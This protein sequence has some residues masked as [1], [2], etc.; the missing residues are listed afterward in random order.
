VFG[1][2]GKQ[3]AFEA[4]V[5]PHLDA[6]YRFAC[7]LC[8]SRAEAEDLVQEACLRA[9]AAFERF[10]PGTNARAWL[11]TI[12]RRVYLNER[13]RRGGRP[14]VQ[15]LDGTGPERGPREIAD[16]HVRTPE[17]EALHTAERDLVLAALHELPEAFR[18]VLALVDLHGLQYA[19]AADVLGC[20]I[21]TVMSRLYRGRRQLARRLRQAGFFDAETPVCRPAHAAEPPMRAPSRQQGRQEAPSDA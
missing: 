7:A 6:A 21:G 14:A 8:G 18:E 3:R 19:E 16:A 13:R 2:D 11:L 15:S 5:L 20:P 4:E 17:E 10:E 1:R 9:Y 12:L